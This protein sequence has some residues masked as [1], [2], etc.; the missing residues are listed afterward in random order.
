LLKI[1]G[2]ISVLFII[3]SVFAG[4]SPAFSQYDEE[5]LYP[6]LISVKDAAGSIIISFEPLSLPD[7]TYR[8]YRSPT[9]LMS[10]AD[11]QGAVAV[12]DITETGIPYADTPDT[13]GR[14]YYAVT[15]LMNGNEYTDLLPFQNVT[16]KPVDYSPPPDTVE[17]IKIS[18]ADDSS[19]AVYFFPV[20]KEYTY[21]LYISSQPIEDTDGKGPDLILKSEEERFTVKIEPEKPYFFLVITSNRMGV[22]NPTVL[23]GK[24]TNRE[25]FIVKKEEKK[26]AAPRIEVKKKKKLPKPQ[27][28]KPLVSAKSLIERNLKN[29]FYRGNYTEALREFNKILKRKDLLESRRG[30]THFYMGQCYFY[31]GKYDT[32]IRQF[33]L[34]KSSGQYRNRAELWIERCLDIID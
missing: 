27:V 1:V 10:G 33:I 29:N 26:K 32:A 3:V 19:A 21:S 22:T 14:F 15:V 25:A 12:A 2:R 11:L 16:V 6:T 34:S 5:V 20:K 4:L 7:I 23:P 18:R 30:E 31:I 8:I 17:S 28:S 13:D 9:P 24:N